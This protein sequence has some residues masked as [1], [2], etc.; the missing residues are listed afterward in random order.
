MLKHFVLGFGITVLCV[1]VAAVAVVRVFGFS[2]DNTHN[3]QAYSASDAIEKSNSGLGMAT[4]TRNVP[5]EYNAYSSEKA[6]SS[7]YRQSVMSKNTPP[8][9][10]AIY[11]YCPYAPSLLEEYV[12]DEVVYIEEPIVEQ[13]PRRPM[14][15]L[16]FDD[17]PAA[18]TWQILNILENHNARATFFVLG[19]NLERYRSTVLR[20][21]ESGNEL[22]GHSYN[23]RRLI[24]PMTDEQ[25][26]R[27]IQS[28]SA[29][30][31]EIT[32]VP[33]PPMFRPPIG[34]WDNRLVEISY[35]IGYAIIL[36]NHDPSDWLHRDACHIYYHIMRNVR[37]GDIIVLHDIYQTTARAMERVVPGLI[38]L[39]FDLVTVTELIYHNHGRMPM[40][41]QIYSSGR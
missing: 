8:S 27:E 13:V 1:S 32:G 14:V 22:A 28:A 36:W 16:T 30:I 29:A 34:I 6:P 24:P 35:E 39:G 17:G 2:G 31:E 37:N 26:I 9:V 18:T 4:Y 10:N 33:A 12:Y 11:A 23:H 21:F 20:I 19:R 25:I 7:G 15:A 5:Y 41:G 38:R 40:N 3:L